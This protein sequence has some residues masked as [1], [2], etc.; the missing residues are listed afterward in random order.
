M[1]AARTLDPLPPEPQALPQEFADAHASTGILGFWLFLASDVVLFSCLFAVY[2]VYHTRVASGPAAGQLFHY[3]PALL[4]TVILLTSSFSCG[5]AIYAMRRGSRAGVLWWISTTALLGAAFITLELREF[6]ADLAMGASWHRSAFLS[7]FFMLVAT[8]GA[9]VS[10]G[11][12]WAV[13]L[14]LQVFR[15]G[16]TAATRRK[17]YT[18]SLYWHFLDTIWVFIFTVV[19][20][21]GKVG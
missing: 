11:I 15:R 13:V 2:A 16:L 20:L 9:H 21:M 14:L 12:L 18:F 5:L 17:L 6:A 3:G 10:F 7:G 19:Y 4:E 8:H 1:N